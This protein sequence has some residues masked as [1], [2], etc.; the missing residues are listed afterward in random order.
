MIFLAKKNI[1]RGIACIRGI[2]SVLRTPG[3]GAR[4]LMYHSVGGKP[5]DHALA[6]RVPAVNFEA[7]TRE[8]SSRG[9]KTVSVSDL[10]KLG[11]NQASGKYIAITFDDGYKDNFLSAAPILK[12]LKMTATFFVTVSY[13]QNE[14][15]K[16]WSGGE[17]R[18]FMSWDDV[19]NLTD[20]GF[21]VGSHMVH[22]T[23][24]AALN[25]TDI[26]YEFEHSRD[27]ISNRTGRPVRVFSYPYGK[28]SEKMVIAAKKA[29]YIGGCSSFKGINGP[30]TDHFILRRT[31]IDGYDTINDF[32]RKLSG[33]YD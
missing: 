14:V 25:E 24:I 7:Q 16:R 1:K 20:M 19:K 17:G 28:V 32:R 33:L 8:I 18:E 12:D 10:I 30:Y 11:E 2:S 22:H 31:E 13:V 5:S 21:E 23:D 27:A 29:G 15:K 26:R 6:I 9:Y 3:A 4:I